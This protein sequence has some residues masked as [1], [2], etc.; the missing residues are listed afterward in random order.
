MV[1]VLLLFL[2]SHFLGNFKKKFGVNRERAAFVFTPEMAYVMGG[3]NYKKSNFFKQFLQYSMKAFKSL[4]NH[5]TLLES[6]F[7]L[8]VAAGMPELM[9]ISDIHYMR[10]KLC[11]ELSE[12]KAEKHLQ[13]E[14]DKSLDSTYRRIDNFIH[15]MKHG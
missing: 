4:R 13:Q 12:K 9:K 7:I 1:Y 5:A 3:K 11:L 6:L 15:N 2:L 10:E 8:M 14:I